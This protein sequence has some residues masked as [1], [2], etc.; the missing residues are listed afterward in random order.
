MNYR[1]YN[2]EIPFGALAENLVNSHDVTLDEPEHLQT[3]ADLAAFL[4]EH[5]LSAKRLGVAELEGVRTLRAEVRGLFAAVSHADTLRRVNGLLEG[6]RTRL[7]AVKDGSGVRI[8]WSMDQGIDF[9][10]AL[11]SAVAVNVAHLAAEFGVERLRVC[12]ASP[13]IDVFLDTSKRG[14][15]RFCGPRCAT[16]TRV[17]AHRARQD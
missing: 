6:A 3:P 13:C 11:R 12:G 2:F 5:D 7:A 8:A 17:A 10:D 9:I 14:G 15:Q 16:R 4:R 1:R